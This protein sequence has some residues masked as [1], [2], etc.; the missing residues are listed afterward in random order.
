MSLMTRRSDR[1]ARKARQHDAD[2]AAEG[3]ADPIDASCPRV[4][5]EGVHVGAVLQ[6]GVIGRIPQ[7]SASSPADQVRADHPASPR[8]KLACQVVE[9][10]ALPRQA[11]DAD[12]DMVGIRR[13]PFDIGDLVEPRPGQ[14]EDVAG[15]I[16]LD[17]VRFPAIRPM[18]PFSLSPSR[19]LRSQGNGCLGLTAA[20]RRCAGPRRGGPGPRRA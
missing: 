19:R 3:G 12:D 20:S 9:V 14:A 4:G 11:M 16:R 17:G 2:Q 13:P 1:S 7:P 18:P 10:A 6:D 5:D 8:C 15:A